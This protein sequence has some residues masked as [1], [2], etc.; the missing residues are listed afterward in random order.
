MKT[1]KLALLA[2]SARQG[3]LQGA[4]SIH[5]DDD[6]DDDDNTGT[7]AVCAARHATRQEIDTAISRECAI[8]PEITRQPLRDAAFE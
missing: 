8:S 3:S 5:E 6:D 2:L 1:A 7:A 4:V